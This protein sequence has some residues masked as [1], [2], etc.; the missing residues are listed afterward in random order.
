MPLAALPFDDAS[1]ALWR[2]HSIKVFA[3]EKVDA[4]TWAADGA[5]AKAEAS[6]TSV[7]TAEQH[8]AGNAVRR[9]VFADRAADTVGWFWV[10]PASRDTKPGTGWLYDIEIVPAHRGQGLGRE[11]MALAEA[12]A[13]RL[14]Y[15]RL[16]LHVFAQ[17]PV[18]RHLYEA[19]GYGLTDLLYCKDLDAPG[20][21]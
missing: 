13:R 9:V 18:S 12:E 6:L 2:E 10:G 4:G 7:L 8:T 3:A 15:A 11:V 17:N 20:G 16:G 21:T 5:E 14:G 19:C 1:Y